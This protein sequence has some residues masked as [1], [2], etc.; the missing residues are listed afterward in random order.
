VNQPFADHD[1]VFTVGQVAQLLQVQPAFLRRLEAHELISPERSD[2][3][4]RRYSQRDM[5][6]V[7][8]I[9]GLVDEGLTLA[10]VRRVL[11][12]EAEV[13]ALRK[14]LAAEKARRSAA[15]SAGT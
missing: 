1:P 12:L 13:R 11:A 2:G 8:Y 6:D 10:G 9:C 15:P 3:N 4:Q 5:A 14:Q 7:R